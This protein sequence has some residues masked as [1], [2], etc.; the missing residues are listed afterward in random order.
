MGSK[1]RASEKVP[2]KRRPRKGGVKRRVAAA[3]AT[4]QPITPN[5]GKQEVGAIV[6]GVVDH[7][8]GP[9]NIAVDESGVED[10]G[11][12]GE[13][14]NM[15]NATRGMAKNVGGIGDR[16]SVGGGSL[17]GG[18]RLEQIVESEHIEDEDIVVLAEAAS[19]GASVEKGDSS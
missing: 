12:G 4:G 2:P 19:L 1:G 3:A 14:G 10:S 7:G 16:V 17:E 13:G 8:S 15:K 9:P 6:G 18:K 5:D 11:K